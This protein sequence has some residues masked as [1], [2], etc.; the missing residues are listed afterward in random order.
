M[1]YDYVKVKIQDHI[2]TV[3]INRP[4]VMNCISPLV[5]LEMD[6]V[7]DNFN[8]DPQQWVCIITGAGDKL[9]RRQ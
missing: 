2:T 1:N 6:K 3:I 8:A 5:S 9:F 7:F 4:N